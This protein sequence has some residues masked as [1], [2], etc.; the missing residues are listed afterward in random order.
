MSAMAETP[1]IIHDGATQQDTMLDHLDGESLSEVFEL[2][3]KDNEADA[4]PGEN[5]DAT[6]VQVDHANGEKDDANSMLVAKMFH[7]PSLAPHRWTRFSSTWLEILD[8]GWL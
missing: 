2:P 3:T 5:N 1:I 7:V 6:S 4:R 8:P